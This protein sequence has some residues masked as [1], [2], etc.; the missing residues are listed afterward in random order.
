MSS[1]IIIKTEIELIKN[2]KFGYRKRFML[3]LLLILKN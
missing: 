1:A 2:R 3:K